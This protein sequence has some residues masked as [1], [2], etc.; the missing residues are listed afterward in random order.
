ML[1]PLNNLP[2]VDA[3]IETIE[4]EFTWAQQ[5]LQTWVSVPLDSATID[6]A[7]SPTTQLRPGLVLGQITSS[8]YYTDY[9][10]TA[11]DG[12]QI[13]AGILVESVNMYD[14][15]AGAV[16][17][18]QG[19]M[20]VA[21]FVKTGSLQANFDEFARAFMARRFIYDDLRQPGGALKPVAKTA[22]YTVVA[23]DN[24]THF[25]TLGASGAVNFT[26]PAITG[27]RGYRFRF[28][29]SVDQ[30]MTVTAPSGK[31]ITFNNA[32]ATSVAFSTAGNKIGASVEIVGLPDSTKYQ[33]LPHGANTMTVA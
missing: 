16:R 13:P 22:D 20:L 4:N 11:T 18:K 17:V 21:G 26:L 15:N 10:P 25:F 7:N 32:A 1:A 33:A 24:Y 3:S 28:S 9:D 27:C 2:G 6:S 8:G 14:V 30:N 29:N 5:Q 19:K 12:S 23:A 31:L